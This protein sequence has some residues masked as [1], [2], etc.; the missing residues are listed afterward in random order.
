MKRAT[1]GENKEHYKSYKAGKHWLYASITL[2]ALGLGTATVETTVHADVT[3]GADS[4]SLVQKQSSADTSSSVQSSATGST[5]SATTS[6]TPQTSDKQAPV[7]ATSKAQVTST[8]TETPAND[9][10]DATDNPVHND[11]SVGQPETITQNNNRL[12]N[13]QSAVVDDADAND[14]TNDVSNAVNHSVPI[15]TDGDKIAVAES[16]SVLDPNNAQVWMPDANLR[17][18]IEDCIQKTYSWTTVNDANL[19]QYLNDNYKIQMIQPVSTNDVGMITSLKGL[20]RVTN[21]IHFQ[22][23]MSYFDPSAMI[24]LSF[25]PNLTSFELSNLTGVPVNWGMT[26]NDLVQKYLHA[27][28]KLEFFRA[29]QQNLTGGIPDFSNNPEIENIY[30]IENQLTGTIPSLRYLTNLESINVSQNQLTGNIENLNQPGLRYVSVQYNQLSGPIAEFGDSLVEANLNNN[31]FTGQ[32]PDLKNIEWLWLQNN[33]FSGDLPNTQK[34]KNLLYFYNNFTSGILSNN[35]D[36]YQGYNGWKQ[37]IQ[38]NDVILTDDNMTF[39]PSAVI[40]GL[41]DLTTGENQPTKFDMENFKFDN[42]TSSVM[43][44]TNVNGKNIAEDAANTFKIT[45]DAN[46]VY[47]FTGNKDVK[48]GTYLIYLLAQDATYSAYVYINVDNQMTQTAP[49]EPVDPG[50]L[51]DPGTPS[52]PDTPVVPETPTTPNPIVNGGDG[53][54][55]VPNKNEADKVTKSVKQLAVH[56][57]GQAA[58]GQKSAQKNTTVA[59]NTKVEGQ[60]VVQTAAESPVTKADKT[61][62]TSEKMATETLPQT[63]EKSTMSSFVAGVLVLLTTLGFADARRRH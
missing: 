59:L 60:K 57:N 32:L 23:D 21:L 4:S 22:M 45:Q 54:A 48:S 49:T 61:M 7:T 11:Q 14:T 62:T 28:S 38:G 53:D 18:Y 40:N 24:D 12:A 44:I 10:Q 41:Q 56:Q 2:L 51:V 47:Q 5:S 50:T 1:I 19:Y 26:A 39:E 58:K 8:T 16:A 46:G 29:D 20:E 25:A 31:Q 13:K 42:L 36:T 3:P 52:N 55:I 37:S 9:G 35:S 43:R 30:M 17:A 6:Q 33:Q 63:N 27:N 34:L 15:T